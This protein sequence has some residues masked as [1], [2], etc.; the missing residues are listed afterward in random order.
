MSINRTIFAFFFIL[1]GVF[2]QTALANQ[3]IYTLFVIADADPSIG[4]AVEV[5]LKRMESAMGFA[6]SV[7]NVKIDA[8]LSS[9]GQLKSN[10]ILGWLNGIKPDADD[11]V[12]VYY[13]GHGGMDR[14]KNTFLYL[15]DGIFYRS[16]LVEAIEKLKDKCRLRAIIT[17]CC[18][19]GPEPEVPTFRAT[20]DP[21]VMQNLF[22]ESEGLVHISAASEGEYSWCSP[23][24]G[25]WFTRAFAESLD[26]SSDNNKDGFVSWD[27][28]LSITRD[29]VQKK[30]EQAFQYFSNEQ[31]KDMKNRGI[32]SQTPRSYSM[33]K[34]KSTANPVAN[35]QESPQKQSDRPV[36]NIQTLWDIQNPRSTFS[37]SVQ[38]DKTKYS[39]G[40][41]ITF[42]IQ[43][44]ADCYVIILNWNSVGQPIQLFP[45]K[46]NTSN[47]AVKGKE[48][49]YPSDESGFDFRA[50]GSKG[51][52]KI[53]VI[54]FRNRADSL[55][56]R[57]IL[58]L[59]DG[60]GSILSRIVVV[61]RKSEQGEITE[62]KIIE[63]L[64]KIRQFDWTTANYTIQVQ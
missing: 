52:E 21:K 37:V 16:K 44:T 51:E 14:S 47:F 53:K 55:K 48:Y 19:N 24:Y 42:K 36:S 11:T 59:D 23:K 17:D 56:I 35:Y 39:A 43:P 31:K 27:E 41:N 3:T 63:A 54:A 46:Y 30:Y 13:S 18:S 28:M 12:F 22:L 8:F 1:M 57:N 20:P 6:K 15:Q 50:S 10:L 9:N 32:A 26:T 34:R 29:I 64:S 49:L 4:R 62:G 45:N 60:G 58:P 33:P 61:P 25:G 2:S 7:C 40:S 5:D 38:M